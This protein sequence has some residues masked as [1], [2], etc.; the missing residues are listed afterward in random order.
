MWKP[1]PGMFDDYIANPKPNNYQ[2][3]HTTVLDENG[4][5]V[6]IQIRDKKMHEIAEYGIAAHWRYKENIKTIDEF[7]KK[8]GI[9]RHLL[10]DLQKE[11]YK[12]PKEFLD[13]FKIKLFEDEVLVFTPKGDVINL[14]QN[15]TPIDFAYRIHTEIGN[16]C[17]GAKV[18]NRIVPLSYKLQNGDIVEIITSKDAKPSRDW[19]S[20]VRSSHTRS[21]IKSWFR[22]QN[23]EESILEGRKVIEKEI[24]K[25]GL[26]PEEVMQEKYLK[27]ISEKFRFKDYPEIF[28]A[29][30][31]GDISPQTVVNKLEQLFREEKILKEMETSKILLPKEPAVK[32]RK[33]KAGEGIIVEGINN[34]LVKLSKCCSPL[35]GEEIIGYITKGKGV[36]IHS[37]NCSNFPKVP[38][39]VV[40]AEW[41]KSKEIYCPAEIEIISFDRVGLLNEITGIISS[42]KVNISSAK[43][44]TKK[45]RTKIN[46]CVE[47]E[48]VNKLNQIIRK[49]KEVKG[50]FQIRR[51][52]L[53]EE[54][55]YESSFAKS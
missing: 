25:Q 22:K 4:D 30:G 39:R 32:W 21:K 10:E 38:A 24:I 20:F 36:T 40:K 6:E 9:L 52:F 11:Y 13:S 17:I 45:G 12:N 29:V 27:R 28:S 44:T 8:I 26:S 19:L 3:I 18:N 54:K 7:E 46:L 42:F 49:I 43:M 31:Y 15:S 34:I 53:T 1:I 14:P 55:N 37:I 23:K 50:V 48:D 16:H 47:I 5:P 2:S 35:P 41:D 51:V 33:V